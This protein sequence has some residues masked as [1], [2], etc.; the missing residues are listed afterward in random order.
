[1]S[2]TDEIL[3]VLPTVIIAGA[4]T[5]IAK[6]V[7]KERHGK[8]PEHKQAKLDVKHHKFNK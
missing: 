8:F 6:E 2:A 4:V 1:M 5:H 7:L 3:E